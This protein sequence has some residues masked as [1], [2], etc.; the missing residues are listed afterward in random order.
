[1]VSEKRKNKEKG[2]KGKEMNVVTLG[3]LLMIRSW[4]ECNTVQL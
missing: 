3:R 1:M 2:K 4:E